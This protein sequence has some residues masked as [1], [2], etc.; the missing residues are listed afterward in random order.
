VSKDVPYFH[1]PGKVERSW[2]SSA[3]SPPNWRRTP[4]AVRPGGI[5]RAEAPVTAD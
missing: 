3:A 5:A 2:A 4:V 1:L